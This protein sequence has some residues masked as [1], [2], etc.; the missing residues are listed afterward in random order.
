MFPAILVFYLRFEGNHTDTR[1]I[2]TYHTF[3][4]ISFISAFLNGLIAMQSVQMSLVIL[5][6]LY[7]ISSG[8][9]AAAFLAFDRGEFA[10]LVMIVF[11]GLGHGALKSVIHKMMKEEL[12]GKTFGYMSL[13]LVF[14]Q[15]LFIGLIPMGDIKNL[16]FAV[17]GLLG[18]VFLLLL[19]SILGSLFDNHSSDEHKLSLV[20]SATSCGILNMFNSAEEKTKEV[21][22]KGK[23]K[24]KGKKVAAKKKPAPVAVNHWMDRCL[25]SSYPKDLVEDLKQKYRLHKFYLSIA[26][27]WIGVE[28]KYSYWIFN[29]YLTRRT[30]VD[31]TSAFQP[32]QYIALTPLAFLILAPF[33]YFYIQPILSKSFFSTSLRQMCLGAYL[34]LIGTTLGWRLS[35]M[36]VTLATEFTDAN[37]K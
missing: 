28:M 23:A 5:M 17:L 1:S 32:P 18:V 13:I 25:N 14:C 19:V 10:V 33:F 22:K 21:A 2:L 24:L 12:L 3:Q 31:G 30:A 20:I 35:A 6:V 8:C 36:E 11:F 7:V 16:P 27:L 26:G 29:S 34:I 4:M 37:Q 9:L 15:L